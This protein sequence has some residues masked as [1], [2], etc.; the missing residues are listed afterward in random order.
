MSTYGVEP[1]RSSH[2]EIALRLDAPEANRILLTLE[3]LDQ[4]GGL[5]PALATL[6]ETLKEALVTKSSGDTDSAPSTE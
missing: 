6:R 2:G 5:D 1:Y 3:R 4:E